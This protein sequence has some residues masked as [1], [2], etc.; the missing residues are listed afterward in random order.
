MSV[1]YAEKIKLSIQF[2]IFIV[3][4]L[5]FVILHIFYSVYEFFTI[6]I[7]KKNLRYRI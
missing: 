5:T 2:K 3:Y 6:T 1:L 4:F 7:E